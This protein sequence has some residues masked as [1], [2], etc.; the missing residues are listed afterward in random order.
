MIHIME[1]YETCL[2]KIYEKAGVDLE[3]KKVHVR[4]DQLTRERF[5]GAKAMRAHHPIDKDKFKHLSPITFELFYLHMNMLK[6]IFKTLYC[7]DSVQDIGTLKSLQE[8][9]SRSNVNENVNEHYDAD[10]DFFISVTDM[11]IVE[12]LLEFFGMDDVNSKPSKNIPPDFINDTEKKQWY[13]QT[14]SKMISQQIFPTYTYRQGDEVLEG[15]IITSV[16]CFKST[17]IINRTF[18]RAHSYYIPCAIQFRLCP[19]Y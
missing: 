1:F 18:L 17:A 14:I 7:K 19:V 10:K 9:I 16:K 12:C 4:G 5:S 2:A 11:Y 13:F 3:G 15:N 8:R 6:M